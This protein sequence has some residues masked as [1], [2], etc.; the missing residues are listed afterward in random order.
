LTN[1]K[2]ELIKA[3]LYKIVNFSTV[4][5]VIALESDNN[6]VNSDKLSYTKIEQK[7]LVIDNIVDLI[8]N[9]LEESERDTNNDYNLQ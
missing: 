1:Y 4:E 3:K 5:E 7:T 6:I 9:Y 2:R 8:Q